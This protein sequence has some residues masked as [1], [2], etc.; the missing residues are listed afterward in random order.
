V[1]EVGWVV[2]VPVKPPGQAKSRLR[3]ARPGV[4]HGELVA[5]LVGDT[6]AAAARCPAVAELVVVASG[7]VT[8]FPGVRV[9]PEPGHGGLN[10]ALRYAA[11]ALRDSRRVPPDLAV[12]LG[13]LPALD[14]AELAAAL[15]AAT[16]RSFV[17]DA[18]GTGTTLLAA[19]AGAELAPRFGPGSAA[20][21]RQSGAV[22]LTGDW[23]TLRRDVDTGAD[24]TAA[25]ALG[26]GPRTAELLAGAP[27]GGGLP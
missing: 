3:G 11:A 8:D 27:A 15:A 2:L 5:A 1:A 18:A 17:A 26:L 19:P 12:L 20:A 23:P 4:A 10:G 13:D 7:P 9:L 21:H 16:A 6:L 14:P 22:A 24:L 25:A